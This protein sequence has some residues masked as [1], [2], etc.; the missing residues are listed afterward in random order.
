MSVDSSSLCKIVYF[1]EESVADY[2]QIVVGGQL[3]KT[4]ESS[5]QATDNA[6]TGVKSSLGFGASLKAVLKLKAEI[7]VDAESGSQSSESNVARSVI[8]NT[9]LTDFIDMA[10][11][12][13]TL[14][15][16]KAIKVFRGF[17]I[18]APE[19]S[20]AYMVLVTPYLSMVKGGTVIPAGELNISADRLDNALK[21]AKGYYEFIGTDVANDNK[22]QCVFRFNIKS[23]RNNYRA[24]DLLKMN[25][26]I[27][28]I[29][30]GKSCIDMLDINKELNVHA[31]A[32]DNPDYDR[33]AME[34]SS[35]AVLDDTTPLD[36]FDVVLVGVETVD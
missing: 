29:Q 5:T 3:S 14:N 16:N 12:Q 6:K 36:V 2:I 10:S 24:A 25:V 26:V 27:Y 19:N 28:A 8:T 20:F 13:D 34:P 35:K 15:K 32:K 4:G 33:N 21:A 31:V 30:V 11:A 23:F 7:N 9:I 17:R 1:D 22:K 18:S